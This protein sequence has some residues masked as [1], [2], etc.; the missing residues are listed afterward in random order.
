MNFLIYFIFSLNFK[1][2]IRKKFNSYYKFKGIQIWVKKKINMLF[3]LSSVLFI[4]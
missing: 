2:I 4:F 3:T 1:E